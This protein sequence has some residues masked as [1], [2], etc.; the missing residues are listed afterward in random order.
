MKRLS[1][2]VAA[3]MVC[4]SMI[5]VSTSCSTGGDNEPDIPKP[6]PAPDPDPEPDPEPAD[7]SIARL[8]FDASLAGTKLPDL[9]DADPFTAEEYETVK[10]ELWDKWKAANAAFKEPVLPSPV[11]MKDINYANPTAT[12]RWAVTGGDMLFLYGYKGSKP[13]G[14]F[15]LFIFLHGSGD[16]QAEW[17]A[18]SSWCEYFNDAPAAYF[19]P[20][21]PAG[22]TGCRWYQPS[23]Q[24]A[25]ERVIRR[26]YLADDINPD[27]IY[28]TGI[29]EG[30]YGSQRLASFYA[31][32]LAGAGPIAGG[33]P[34]Y[35]CPPENTANIAYC[36]QTGAEDTMY[37]RARIVAKAKEEW[38]RLQQAHP[39]YYVHKIDLQPNLGHGCDYTVTTPWLKKYSRNPWPKYV[40]WENYGMGNVNGESYACRSGF[41]NL[42]VLEGQNGKT[43]GADR[44]TYEMTIEGND[45]DLQVTSV[46][47]RPDESVSE[48][49][50]TISVGVKKTST[51]ATRGKIRIYLCKELVDLAKPVTVTV[52]GLKKYE[53]TVTLDRRTMIES[54]AFFF[55]PRRIFPA[56]VD[57]CV[58]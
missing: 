16:N 6:A 48:N 8:Y 27:K 40:F 25:W 41:Y 22:G 51:P 13:V 28:F 37:G 33:E 29:S 14:G 1:L 46:N 39:G 20:R 54:L 24:Q 10:K 12:G 36:Q 50:W 2:L 42:R 56:A 55:D 3:A 34:F 44:D 21:S 7:E 57:V 45:I 53:G 38:A 15:P 11:N 9:G 18:C 19:I 30:G 17:T 35:N 47:V 58:E 5:F 26:A 43:D 4:T 52:N 31:D 49:G 23:R 32:Y